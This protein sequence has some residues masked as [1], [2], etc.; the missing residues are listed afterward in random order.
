M[1]GPVSRPWL[2][3]SRRRAERPLRLGLPAIECLWRLGVTVDELSPPSQRRMSEGDPDGTEANIISSPGNGP[4]NVLEAVW[5]QIWAKLTKK[6]AELGDQQWGGSLPTYPGQGAPSNQG[7]VYPIFTLQD[8]LQAIVASGETL[9]FKIYALSTYLS[10]F[11]DYHRR[12]EERV[13]TAER[14]FSAT[15]PS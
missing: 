9:K 6:R 3:R 14:E 15:T 13:F 2:P 10:F 5:K 8:I 12:L 4:L 1:V 7:L 11:I